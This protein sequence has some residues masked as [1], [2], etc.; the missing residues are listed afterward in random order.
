MI[1]WEI[2]K[3]SPVWILYGH[4]DGETFG[5]GVETFT[6]SAFRQVRKNLSAKLYLRRLR[7]N[8]NRRRDVTASEALQALSDRYNVVQSDI[9]DSLIS[10]SAESLFGI[11]PTSY[12]TWSTGNT[13]TV[14]DNSPTTNG[15]Y[16]VASGGTTCT[17]LEG[18]INGIEYTSPPQPIENTDAGLSFERIQSAVNRAV[19]RGM[20]W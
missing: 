15:T 5:E 10:A 14:T 7:Y 9:E 2:Y 1:K 17:S 4:L 16:V 3:D 11:N 18:G 20:S 19:S 6:F 12:A 13:I 8:L